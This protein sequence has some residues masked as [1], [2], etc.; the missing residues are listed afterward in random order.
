MERAGTHAATIVARLIDR[1]RYPDGFAPT[2]VG[3]V[4]VL[5]GGGDNG[6]DARI[7]ARCLHA[8][9]HDVRLV[10][11]SAD[12]RSRVLTR[13]R[14]D[15]EPAANLSDG[16]F[17]AALTTADVVVDGLL[18]TGASGPLRGE[19]ARAARLLDEVTGSAPRC[20][21]VVALDVPTG[22][23]A[24][25]GAVVD[26]AVRAAVTVAFGWPKLGALLHP[27]RE[28]AGR[29]LAVEIGFPPGGTEHAPAGDTPGDEAAADRAPTFAWAALDAR[30]ARSV[31]PRR[32]ADAHKN[33]AGP[34]L[35]VAG[36]EGMAGAA[37]LAGRAALRSGAGYVRIASVA[38]NRIA[39]QAAVPEAVW[40]DRADPVALDAAIAASRAVVVGPG[41]GTD[42]AA[43][44]VLARI[45]GAGIPVV[46]D[47]DALTLVA[48]GR[49]P[50]ASTG[51]AA[52]PRV[53]TPHPGEAARLLGVDA[54]TVQEDRPAALERLRASTGAVVLLK[55]RPSLVAGA[56]RR[57][58]PTGSSDLATAGVGDVLA[59]SIAAQIARGADPEEA[60]CLGLW[61]TSAAARIAGRGDGMQSI[62]LL[63]HIPAALAETRAGPRSGGA[64]PWV[65]FDLP[66]PGV[67][68]RTG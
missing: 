15:P 47:A 13:G 20:P 66:D 14:L 63:D 28:Y 55:G 61:L 54:A 10:E 60:A 17:G 50:L 64:E 5:A 33:D 59:G 9:G 67:G 22:I 37:I 18:G 36:S 49:V 7:V 8:W 4:V 23:D 48:E 31:L 45:L 1:S 32:K 26:H 19:V 41:M 57:L 53:L 40:V 38:S 34:V 58:D 30:W 25:S 27:A 35:V 6:G 51:G 12:D 11:T 39:V 16:E 65:T 43:A 62:D 21:L 68:G 24:D 42:A 52:A 29:I 3:R 46:V 44:D 56:W 2:S